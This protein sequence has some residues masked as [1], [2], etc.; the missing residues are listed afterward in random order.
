MKMIISIDRVA[1]WRDILRMKLFNEMTF[2]GDDSLDPGPEPLA[3]L[4]HGVPVQEPHQRLHPLNLDLDFVE[5]LCIDLQYNTETPHTKYSK[6][7]QSGELG[8]QSSFSH[9]SGTFSS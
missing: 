5:K 4:R 8:G 7:L 6:G 9:N 2:I 3:G 1:Y